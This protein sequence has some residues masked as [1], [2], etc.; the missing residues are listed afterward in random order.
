M[1]DKGSRAIIIQARMGSER[2]PGKVLRAIDGKTLLD[3]LI[4]RL[5]LVKNASK[6]IVATTKNPKD[7]VLE[8][9]CRERN[10]PCFRGSEEN[11]LERYLLAA[12][13]FSVNTLVRVTADCPLIDPRIIDRTISSYFENPCDYASNSLQRTYPRGMDVEVFSYSA[14]KRSAPLASKE[15]QEHVTLFIYR[16]PELFRLLSV[17]QKEN[18]SSHRWTVDTEEDFQL[19]SKLYLAVSKEHPHFSLEDLLQV[20][21]KH[22]EW[23]QINAH[24]EQKK[25]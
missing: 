14:L 16:H 20:C 17:T 10:I 19:V 6:V 18:S 5:L 21:Q 22:P 7:D 8:L 2:L 11:V 15:E 4:D 1:K 25:T 3:I 12:D 13:F 24:I 23:K 9:K